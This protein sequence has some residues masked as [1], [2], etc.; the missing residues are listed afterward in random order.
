MPTDDAQKPTHTRMRMLLLLKNTQ[1][2]RTPDPQAPSTMVAL[3]MNGG[4]ADTA[5]YK[6]YTGR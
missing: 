4:V 5:C 6:Y 1:C 3:A 2:V